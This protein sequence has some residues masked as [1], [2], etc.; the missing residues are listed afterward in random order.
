MQGPAGRICLYTLWT[1]IEANLAHVEV[2]QGVLHAGLCLDQRPPQGRNDAIL[3]W[4][5]GLNVVFEHRLQSKSKPIVSLPAKV[6]ALEDLCLQVG[7]S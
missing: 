2:L 6:S 4:S 3:A 5:D 1:A 7:E